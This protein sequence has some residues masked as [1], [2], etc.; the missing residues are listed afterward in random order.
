MP[1]SSVG[2]TFTASLGGRHS[3]L[4]SAHPASWPFIHRYLLST[5]EV[6]ALGQVPGVSEAKGTEVAPDGPEI[7]RQTQPLK[8]HGIQGSRVQTVACPGV[9]IVGCPGVQIW[10]ALGSISWAALFGG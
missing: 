8:L 10:A 5:Y 4:P 1:G 3:T 7:I 6:P 9:Q 2:T